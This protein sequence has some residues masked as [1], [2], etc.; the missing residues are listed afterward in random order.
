MTI[1][2]STQLLRLSP[3]TI[4]RAYRSLVLAVRALPE[5]EQWS[6]GTA[7]KQ[8]EAAYVVACESV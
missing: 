3:A 6:Y 5:A 7:I 1:L 8:Y 2:T 4:R